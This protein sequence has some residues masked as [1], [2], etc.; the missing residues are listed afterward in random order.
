[1]PSDGGDRVNRAPN[2]DL[3]VLM[4][5]EFYYL[6]GLFLPSFSRAR[7]TAALVSAV[8]KWR[9]AGYPV[10]FDPGLHGFTAP[11]LST[12]L[13]EAG[14]K[15]AIVVGAG[16]D[17]N[18]AGIL[19]G[20]LRRAGVECPEPLITTS[21]TRETPGELLTHVESLRRSARARSDHPVP[22]GQPA[23]PFL[24]GEEGEEHYGM[25]APFEERGSRLVRTAEGPVHGMPRW[26]REIRV[27]SGGTEAGDAGLKDLSG[28]RTDS[29]GREEETIHAVS[30][31]PEC[32]AS[33]TSQDG[34]LDLCDAVI[35]HSGARRFRLVGRDSLSSSVS[36]C[37]GA[38]W[39][40]TY[41]LGHPSGL[42]LLTRLVKRYFP[43]RRS[44][45]HTLLGFA[46]L[47][48]DPLEEMYA[49]NCIADRNAELLEN[50]LP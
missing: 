6:E 26:C 3:W 50:I 20:S 23:S 34:W 46:E 45:F 9:A 40:S 42:R 4:P 16:S 24:I 28:E 1:M 31:L 21:D 48:V 2:E 15:K 44:Y 11:R 5:P 12:K 49:G 8:L 18:G 41:G 14:A 13:R 17:T 43:E 37:G 22:F 25:Y 32:A 30:L 47:G 7:L 10:S 39:T 35:R 36:A 33:E 38:S 19:A 29:S 27:T